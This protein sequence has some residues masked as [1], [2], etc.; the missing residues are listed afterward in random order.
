MGE[1]GDPPK[2]WRRN[3]FVLA[4]KWLVCRLLGEKRGEMHRE[5]DNRRRR[6]EG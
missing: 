3:I 6:K 5:A 2:S 1:T 4:V